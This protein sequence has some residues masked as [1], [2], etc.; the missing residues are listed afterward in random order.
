MDNSTFILLHNQITNENTTDEVKESHA[1]Y[2]K[3]QLVLLHLTLFPSIL[4]FLSADGME[5]IL[6][7]VFKRYKQMNDFLGAIVTENDGF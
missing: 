5:I 1:S 4:A 7:D 3:L 6:G 2:F